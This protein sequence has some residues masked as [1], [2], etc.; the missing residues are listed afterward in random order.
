MTNTPPQASTSLP[1]G[2]LKHMS[3]GLRLAVL[4]ALLMVLGM[5]VMSLVIL[6]KQNEVRHAQIQDFG[7]ALSLQ[8]AA[9]VVEPLFT[10]DQVALD[11]MT[12][13]FVKLPRIQG[14]A[15]VD[16]QGKVVAQAGYNPGDIA[17]LPSLESG[18]AAIFKAP[19]DFV[20]FSSPIAFKGVSA[21]YARITIETSQHSRAHSSTLRT[22]LVT[23]AIVTL[24]AIVVAWFISRYVSRPINQILEAIANIG[25]GAIQP[26]TLE[27]RGDELG[28][29]MSAINQMGQGLLQKNQVESLLSKFLAKDVADEMLSQLD[30]VNIGGARVDATVL[31][32]DIVGFTSMSEQISPEEV[33]EFLNEYYGYFTLCSRFF[34]GTVDKFIGD[35]AMVVFGAPKANPEHS[36]HAVCCA[37]L[38]Q[39]LMDRLNQA[40]VAEGKPAVLVRIGVNSGEMLAGIMG[41]SERMEYTVVGDSVNL[42]SRLCNE[43]SGGQVIIEESLFQKLAPGE[44]ILA[45][46][47]KSIR[48]R[49]KALPSTIYT[50]EDVAAEHRMP[51][52]ALIDDVMGKKRNAA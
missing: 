24:I 9:G 19:P 11:V 48:L 8:L 34:F 46:S 20:A 2:Q 7:T 42:A 33:A 5:G 4:I 43:S 16:S 13:N 47:Y 51:M 10:N 35:C 6:V 39:K 38:I 1:L 44:R 52:Q 30:T 50:V 21:G 45:S 26:N 23:C 22:L 25:S 18:L 17:P 32:A 29:L 28:Q 49:G 27:R 41:D 36:F 15:I 37:I 12:S 3:L 31:F 14:A 40:R